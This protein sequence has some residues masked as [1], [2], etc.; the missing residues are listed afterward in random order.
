[1]CQHC[2]NYMRGIKELYLGRKWLLYMNDAYAHQSFRQSGY[3]SETPA[4]FI[5]RRVM[6][7]RML[8]SA[9]EGGELEV[10][11][12]WMGVWDY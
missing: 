5:S 2:V 10:L 6:H 8:V 4:Q 3:R 7:T 9:P 1:M 11:H 12:V